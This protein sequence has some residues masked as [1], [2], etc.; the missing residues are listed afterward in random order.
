MEELLGLCSG[1]FLDQKDTGQDSRKRPESFP[2]L[3]MLGDNT[4]GTD[5]DEVLGL[6]SGKFTAEAVKENDQNCGENEPCDN[7]GMGAA[8]SR[9]DSV[10]DELE[11]KVAVD[12]ESE[13]EEGAELELKSRKRGKEKRYCSGIRLVFGHTFL[14]NMCALLL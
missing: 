1:K 3:S 11:L 2:S 10:F 8:S 5:M 4:Q 12:S 7:G 13:E 9:A 6:C 14:A